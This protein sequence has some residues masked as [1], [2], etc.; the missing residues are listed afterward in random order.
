MFWTIICVE[1][2]ESN[3]NEI[4]SPAEKV[5]TADYGLVQISLALLHCNIPEE[6]LLF[7]TREGR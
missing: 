6:T 3:N 5:V 1:Y 2:N 4:I 7:R